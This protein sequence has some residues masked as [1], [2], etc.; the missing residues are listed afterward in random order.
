[1]ES[2]PSARPEGG[3]KGSRPVACIWSFLLCRPFDDF[4]RFHQ[5]STKRGINMTTKSRPTFRKRGREIAR[6]QKQEAKEAR[7]LE[8]KKRKAKAK[9]RIG[10]EDPDIAGIRPGPQPLPKQWDDDRDDE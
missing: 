9:P 2:F 3:L 8:A 4:L 6:M 5:A 7:R 10:N 1:L